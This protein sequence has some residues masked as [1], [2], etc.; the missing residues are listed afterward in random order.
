MENLNAS[1]EQFLNGELQENEIVEMEEKIKTD[2][3][4]AAEV[5]FYI[6]AKDAAKRA[7]QEKRKAEWFKTYKEKEAT[8]KRI[9]YVTLTGSFAAAASLVFVLFQF[10]I[11]ID[12]QSPKEYAANYIENKM[13]VL[14]QQMGSTEDSL[15]TAIAYF[16][17]GKIAEAKLIFEALPQ[18]DTVLEY[19]GILALKQKNYGN[20]LMLFEKLEKSNESLI[21]KGGFYK[22]ITLLQLDRKE[23]AKVV[24]N[25]LANDPDAFG[26]AEAKELLKNW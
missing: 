1:I 16:N 8:P 11:N 2:K 17:E 13:S 24:L 15:S 9:N 7:A 25:K 20:A 3:A 19:Q 26:N 22:S 23:E 5:A 18:K 14:P 4:F 6:V 21:N 12:A 10:L